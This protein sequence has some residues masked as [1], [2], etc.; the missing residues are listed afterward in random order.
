V[1]DVATDAGSDNRGQ[2]LLFVWWHASQ[3][4]LDTERD[5]S[6]CWKEEK[7]EHTVVANGWIDL[8]MERVNYRSWS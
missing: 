3:S 4:S 5:A 6:R 7:D 2:L 8:R 1:T